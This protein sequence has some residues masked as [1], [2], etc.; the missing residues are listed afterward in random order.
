MSLV[1]P[2]LKKLQR[3]LFVSLSYKSGFVV[4]DVLGGYVVLNLSDGDL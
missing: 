2:Q 1:N 4:K 3:L